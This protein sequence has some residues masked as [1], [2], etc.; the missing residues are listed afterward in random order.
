LT[1]EGI[2]ARH[3]FLEFPARFGNPFV[4]LTCGAVEVLLRALHS[5]VK[6][7]LRPLHLLAG[8]FEGILGHG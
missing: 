4:S 7:A 6:L 1:H 5:L 2:K 8:F 3:P